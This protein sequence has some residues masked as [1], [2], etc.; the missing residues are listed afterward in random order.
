MNLDADGYSS[1]MVV[2]KTEVARNCG[3]AARRM[4]QVFL[5][6]EKALKVCRL[7]TEFRR[8]REAAGEPPEEAIYTIPDVRIGYAEAVEPRSKKAIVRPTGCAW[9]FRPKGD[10]RWT[11]E[12]STTYLGKLLRELLKLSRPEGYPAVLCRLAREQPT[13]AK[14]QLEKLT[15]ERSRYGFNPVA[16]EETDGLSLA[17]DSVKGLLTSGEAELEELGKEF[18]LR[19]L[20]SDDGDVRRMGLGLA[21]HTP[22]ISPAEAHESSDREREEVA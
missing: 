11:V 12:T 4:V 3:S 17:K 13:T 22:G 20:E 1:H 18:V 9:R 19:Y 2:L 15:G 16:L 6:L 21:R 14:E 5:S 7:V 10:E 8:F